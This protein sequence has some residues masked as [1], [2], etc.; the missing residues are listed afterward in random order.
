MVEVASDGAEGLLACR[1]PNLELD[2]SLL[3][4]NHPKVS[5]LHPNSYSLLFFKGLLCQSLQNASL[6]YSSLP[7]DYNFE[8]DV[9]VVHDAI[10]V[11][12]VLDGD[13]CWQVVDLRVQ[14]WVQSVHF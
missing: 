1:V 12:L 5:K 2:V 6:P 9:E 3:P 10:V 4:N 7:N 8:E 11:H 14:V 13:A